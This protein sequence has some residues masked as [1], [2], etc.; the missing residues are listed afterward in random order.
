MRRLFVTLG[1]RSFLLY[2]LASIAGLICY[3]HYVLNGT[4]GFREARVKVE[5]TSSRTSGRDLFSQ[6]PRGNFQQRA[7]GGSSKHVHKTYGTISPAAP[8]P[9]VQRYIFSL[10][11]W[12]QFTMATVNLLG[13]VCLGEKWNATTVQPFTYNS[14]L[15][16]LR[17]FKPGNNFF[18]PP[19]SP[20]SLILCK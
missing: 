8:A 3:W 2:V 19:L 4:G 12:E 5:T 13:L 16:G 7:A 6:R 15:Y 9:Q 14:R 18:P 20:L 11:Y 17:N 10:N 1:R